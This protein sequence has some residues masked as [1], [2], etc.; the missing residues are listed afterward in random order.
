MK[1]CVL[2]CDRAEMTRLFRLIGGIESLRTSV[3]TTM[4]TAKKST[5]KTTSQTTS[6]SS[7]KSSN[8]K[9]SSRCWPGFEP[10]TGKAPR[11]K[12]SCKPKAGKK[13]AG[14]KQA[15]QK[16]AAA[17]KLEKQGKPNPRRKAA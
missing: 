15:D 9:Q 5:K 16:A 12:G 11:E 13:S 3:Q 17:S 10:V 8:A 6:S 2:S 14:V 1:S 4:T 7:N